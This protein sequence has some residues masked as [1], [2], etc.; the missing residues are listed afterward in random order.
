MGLTKRHWEEADEKGYAISNNDWVCESC[1]SNSLLQEVIRRESVDSSC[2]Y[3]ESETAAP[4]EMLLNEISDAAFHGYTDPANELSYISREGGYQGEVIESYELIQD[5]GHWTDNEKLQEDVEEAFAGSVW[6]RE[7]Y[8]SLTEEERLQ[9]GWRDFV[10]QIKHQTRY[11][12]LEERDD[13]EGE[14]IPPSK[15]LDELGKLLSSQSNK[16]PTGSVLFRV[17]V[18]RPDKLPN[19]AAELGTPPSSLAVV[20]NRMSPAGIPMFYCAEDKNTAA[21][22]T[23]EPDSEPDRVIVVGEWRT[24]RP[25]VL[26]DLTDLP[27][28]PN[29]FD[30]HNRMYAPRLRF[31]YEF[32][33]DLTKPVSRKSSSIDYVP[34]QVVTEYIRRRM[35]TESGEPFDGIRYESSKQGGRISV[36]IFAEQENCVSGGGPRYAPREQM[37]ELVDVTY[38]EPAEIAT[39]WDESN[40]VPS[41]MLD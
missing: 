17:R 4:I 31:L 28:L 20:H 36:V 8:F 32:V 23:Y 22:E 14:E 24:K 11:L 1:V 30:E 2:S 27:Q 19:T 10:R 5:L 6:C 33:S 40:Q 18:V 16:L 39:V 34:T 12:F 26:L 13:A 9:F 41:F 35:R 15:M 21:L 7:H 37:L 25:L 3:C 38:L 29:P